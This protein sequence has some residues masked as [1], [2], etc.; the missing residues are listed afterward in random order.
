MNSTNEPTPQE[1]AME[2]LAEMSPIYMVPRLIAAEDYRLSQAAYRRRVHDAHKMA[3]AA[4]GY[5]DVAPSVEDENLGD[6]SVAN[7]NYYG[8]VPSNGRPQP[9]PAPSTPTPATP[10]A[11]E[12]RKDEK[13]PTANQV[14]DVIM[15]KLD[16]R[17]KASGSQ[18]T[19]TAADWRQWL[20]P[21][22][23]G[24]GLTG[25]TLLGAY[26]LLAPDTPPPTGPAV[27]ESVPDVDTQYKFEI[28]SDKG[29]G[30]QG[31]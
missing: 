21:T 22:L 18:P 5:E 15:A 23:A 7:H 30:F 31:P 14:V 20:W 16:K 25:T 11:N 10:A 4:M 9:Q 28:S 2:A 29:K 12:T 13:R 1:Q 19:P 17:L 6:I 3:A 8:I 24:M 27:V 26:N